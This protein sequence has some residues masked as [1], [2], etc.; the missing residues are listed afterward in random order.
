[1]SDPAS[2][3]AVADLYPQAEFP[4]KVV[5]EQRAAFAHTVAQLIAE[6]AP[7]FDPA[8]MT[9]RASSAGRYVSVTATIRA[10]SREQVDALYAALGAHPWVKVVL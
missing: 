7:D 2:K 5:G 1:M 6:H 8:L 10:D 9:Q 3:E 4:V